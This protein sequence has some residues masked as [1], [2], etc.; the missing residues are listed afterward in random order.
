MYTSDEKIIE[1]IS[2]LKF[3]KIINYDKDF[4][5]DIGML[6][7]TVSKIKKGLNHFTVQQIET[8]CKKYKVNA[9]WIFGT[10]SNV[11]TTEKNMIMK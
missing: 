10:E 8:I 4:C 7:Q 9:N 5:Q 2:L 11:F 1:L 6:E 3:R